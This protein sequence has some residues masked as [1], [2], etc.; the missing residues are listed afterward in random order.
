MSLAIGPI[1]ASAALAAAAPT[2]SEPVEQVFGR[3]QQAIKARDLQALERIAHPDF[4]MQHELGVTE[5]R[6]EWLRLVAAGRL[7]RQNADATEHQ[8]TI[9]SNGL[10]ATRTAL[11]RFRDGGRDQWLRGSATFVCEG[12][13]W[14]QWMHQ[15]S[16]LSE[17]TS[18]DPPARR[19][20]DLAS[21]RIPG[22]AVDEFTLSE[23]D[24][25]LMLDWETGARL[26]LTPLGPDRYG[27][28]ATSFVRLERDAS[29]KL[30][31][32]TRGDGERNWWTARRT[33]MPSRP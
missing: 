15:S 16:L 21:F 5:P 3:L 25:V 6:R 33:D 13:E 28:G 1:L 20:D 32:V 26:P 11:V 27:A 31:A 4:V 12:G 29:G 10:V 24:G 19:A 9:R 2:C 8:V 14:R 23:E 30:V 18:F 7:G 22:R 17:A